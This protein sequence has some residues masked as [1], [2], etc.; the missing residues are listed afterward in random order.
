MLRLYYYRGVKVVPLSECYGSSVRLV[1]SKGLIVQSE[2]HVRVG[3]S[4]R[5]ISQYYYENMCVCVL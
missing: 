1:L 4:S 5:Y 2:W 3:N